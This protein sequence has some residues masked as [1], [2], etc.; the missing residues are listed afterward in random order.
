MKLVRFVDG[1]G[2]EWEVWEVG[3]R[4]QPADLPASLRGPASKQGQ[5]WLCFA[6][7]TERRRLGTYPDDWDALSPHELEALC[8]AATAS[9]VATPP[10]GGPRQDPGGR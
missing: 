10:Y 3:V 8:R 5:R 2:T 6:S 4:Q 7:G 1:T 9:R